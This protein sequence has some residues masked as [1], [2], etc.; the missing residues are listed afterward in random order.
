MSEFVSINSLT[1]VI[2]EPYTDTTPT[3][4]SI[5][6]GGENLV[7]DW[8][9]TFHVEFYDKTTSICPQSAR[10]TRCTNLTKCE[11]V[12]GHKETTLDSSRQYLITM[13]AL[14]SP[15][16]SQC[17]R[18]SASSPMKKFLNSIASSYPGSFLD[19]KSGSGGD[20]QTQVAAILYTN[21]VDFAERRKPRLRVSNFLR[22]Q[23]KLFE[24]NPKV[25]VRATLVTSELEQSVLSTQTNKSIKL[26]TNTPTKKVINSSFISRRLQEK[27]IKC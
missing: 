19:E 27:S 20:G 3:A 11:L 1:R 2:I 8:T 5:G 6:G 17:Q 24:I 15:M 23:L 25:L 12:G 13:E 14:E 10:Q 18:E 4:S 21:I 9:S 7:K 22:R 16:Q 26:R